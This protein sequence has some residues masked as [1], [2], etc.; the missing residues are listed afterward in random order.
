L[1]IADE[2]SKPIEEIEL[3]DKV[4]VE[5]DVTQNSKESKEPYRSIDDEDVIP[6]TWR[7]IDLEIHKLDGSLAKVSLLRPLWWLKDVKAE[8]GGAILLS[9]PEMG[10]EG[11]AM[12]INIGAC[13]VDSR[14]SSVGLRVVTG[15]F[16]HE[17]TRVLDLY[18][19]NNHNEPL[20]VT[21]YHPLWS[22][23]RN[24]WVEAGDLEI[25]EDLKTQT[26]I[27]KLTKIAQ[28]PGLHKVYNIEVHKDHNYYVTDLAILTHNSCLL[29][30]ISN[31]VL[32][33]GKV[34]FSK[35]N[36]NRY[37][38]WRLEK[39]TGG[40]GGSVWKLKSCRKQKVWAVAEDGK[41]LRVRAGR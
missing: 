5:I 37:K 9:I 29:S 27:V 26:G 24:S 15:K 20:G 23:T 4:W 33:D 19:E 6:E 25:G 7:A 22:T 11:K 13:D 12:V 39:D 40:H 34:D 18:F 1:V 8:V 36:N 32:K 28:R 30:G 2:G 17:N 31:K 41:I 3:G 16:T 35:F 38:N 10:I 14:Q 21:S